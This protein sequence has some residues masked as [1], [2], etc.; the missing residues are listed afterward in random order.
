MVLGR[1]K[2]IV[3]GVA[4]GATM[5]VVDAAMH[6]QLGEELHTGGGFWQE[7]LQPNATALLFRA[8]FLVIAAAFG[9]S[10]WRANWRERELRVLEEAIIAFHRRLDSPAM[11]IVSHIRMLQGRPGVTRDEVAAGIVEGIGQDAR[12]ID[13]LAKQYI[14]FSEQVLAGRTNE[15]VETLRAIEAGT[16]DACTS[17][18][19]PNR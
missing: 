8:V 15:A 9:W 6:T 14:R 19:L 1:Y 13:E 2:E 12:S 4:L 16:S 11:R 3:C 7:L 10:L 18:A 17:T 5:W